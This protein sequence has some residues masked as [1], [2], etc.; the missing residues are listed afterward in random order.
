MEAG[1]ALNVIPEEVHLRGTIRTIDPEVREMVAAKVQEI[2]VRLPRLEQIKDFIIAGHMF[3][4]DT[5]EITPTLK[6]KRKEILSRY[7]SDLDSLY[8]D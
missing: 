8:K 2:N 7:K 3:S 6:V 1:V 4:V 5:G